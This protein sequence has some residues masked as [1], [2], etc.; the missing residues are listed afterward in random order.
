MDTFKI[1]SNIYSHEVGKFLT[2]RHD[3]VIRGS[4]VKKSYQ[5]IRCSSICQIASI[6]IFRSCNLLL[7][8]IAEVYNLNSSEID[9]VSIGASQLCM[10][11]TIVLH[12]RNYIE[13]YGDLR[14]QA[15]MKLFNQH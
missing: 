13:T 6:R 12:V 2:H 7:L 4:K 10:F 5:P 15:D 9:W 3:S 14:Y 8:D 11:T 1:T